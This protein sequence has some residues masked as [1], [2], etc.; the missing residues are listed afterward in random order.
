ML[1]RPI[2]LSVLLISTCT[3]QG[4]YAV[5]SDLSGDALVDSLVRTFKPGRIFNYGRARDT[6]FRHID[7]RGDSL[8]CVYTGYRIYLAPGDPTTVA[9]EA[10]INTEHTYPKSKGAARGNGLSDMHHLFPT[11]V[12]VNAA[13]SSQP[14]GELSDD[15]VERWYH[16]DQQQTTTP[17]NPGA[18]SAWA[19]GQ[20][21]EPRD[22]IKGDIARAVF[23]FYTMYQP[24]TEQ[25]D[26]NFFPQMMSTLC[27]WHQQDPVDDTELART[28]AI[29]RYQEGKPNPFVL[30]CSLVRRA[31][32]PELPATSCEPTIDLSPYPTAA[33][34]LITAVYEPPRPT[35]ASI[36]VPT[37]SL[38][39][40]DRRS[41]SLFDVQVRLLE[42]QR[43]DRTQYRYEI[44]LGWLGQVLATLRIRATGEE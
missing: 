29:A 18:H 38:V 17:E 32:C 40:E 15:A 11:R 6:L 14:F 44:Q 43:I 31:F 39:A 8:E 13:R 26:P 3:V 2:L 30:D 22:A 24:E 27:N 25:A 10:K 12:D 35:P 7:S 36:S 41:L 33:T 20:P 42:E 19:G 34:E 1:L 37:V 5:F 4:Q 23:Y 21:F 9:Y 16:L 28:W